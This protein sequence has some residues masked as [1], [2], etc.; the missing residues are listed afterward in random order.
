M[1]IKKQ[2]EVAT[3]GG[4]CFWCGEAIFKMMKGVESVTS[5]YS[6]GDVKNPTYEEVCSGETGHAEVIQVAFDP[7]TISY[8]E[9]LEIFF[10]Y[11][12]PTQMNRQGADVGTQYRS[13]I[14]YHNDRQRK[15]AEEVIKEIGKE[16]IW[17]GKIVTSV[18]KFEAFYKAEDYHQNYFENNPLQPYCL[19]VIA[20]KV[21]KFR[22][23][24]KDKLRK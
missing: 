1:K 14:F 13:V 8:K 17:D 2:A 11:H 3:L 9:I 10:A 19:I 22:Q 21:L 23:K 7:K 5:G 4:G 16:G 24:F 6:G 15:T 20:P 18:E 12:D